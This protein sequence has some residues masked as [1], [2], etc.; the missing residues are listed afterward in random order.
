MLKNWQNDG[1]DVSRVL[2]TTEAPTG[3]A[4]IM[5]GKAGEN[6]LGVAPGANYRLR[7]EHITAQSELIQAAARAVLQ[8]ELAVE[9]TQRIL[10]IAYRSATE[11]LFNFAP[12]RSKQIAILPSMTG[13]VVNE[14]EAATLTGISVKDRPEAVT[15]ARMLLDREPSFVAV[16]PRFPGDGGCCEG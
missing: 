3:V 2:R 6:Y 5:S 10:E 7:P 9:T 14:P 4:L 16:N 1:I 11:A 13:L 15:A 8:M 12:A